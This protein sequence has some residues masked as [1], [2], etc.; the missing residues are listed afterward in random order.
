MCPVPVNRKPAII[1]GTHQGVGFWETAAA[2]VGDEGS[3]S[4]TAKFDIAAGATV[5]YSLAC[6]EYGGS[7]TVA[8]RT[9]TAIFTPAP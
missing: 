4:G 5:T 9:M 1:S 6:E 8:G 2:N 7:G 3:V